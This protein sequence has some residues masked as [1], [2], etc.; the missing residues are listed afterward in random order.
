MAVGTR[1]DWPALLA[2]ALTGAVD[3]VR[4][5]PRS[6]I[7]IGDA[8][9]DQALETLTRHFVAGR[10]DQAEFEQR[11]VVVWQAATA[12]DL[13]SVFTDLPV[14]PPEPPPGPSAAERRRA[15][16]RTR[17]L[18]ALM[19]VSALAVVGVVSWFVVALVAVVW[20]AVPAPA[21]QLRRDR[22]R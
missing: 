14:L 2:G 6:A 7:R 16:L 9:R 22:S 20:G 8:E 3:G 15:A 12:R 10:L 21:R 4:A 13:G 11:S 1:T 5:A 17:L 19:L 18:V